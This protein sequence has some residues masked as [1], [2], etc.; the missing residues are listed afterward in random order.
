LAQDGSGTVLDCPAIVQ[1]IS[2]DPVLR[3]CKVIAWPR[4]EGLLPRGGRRGFPHQGVLLQHNDRFGSMLDW[5]KGA[6]GVK[7]ADVA[8][9]LTGVPYSLFVGGHL[10]SEGTAVLCT[11]EK[12]RDLPC[13]CLPRG[14]AALAQLPLRQCARLPQGRWRRD[15]RR[16]CFPSHWRVLIMLVTGSGQRICPAHYV[17]SAV[18]D[19]E[20]DTMK[21]CAQC[22]LCRDLPSE[23]VS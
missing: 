20:S 15:S 7:A 22:R 4:D 9:Q 12:L 5:L 6:G 21:C 18:V 8:S 13:S 16:C 11:Q 23:L 1:E 10:R 2:Q 14:C 17:S 19:S 3:A